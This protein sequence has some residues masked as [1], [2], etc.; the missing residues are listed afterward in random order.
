MDRSIARIGYGSVLSFYNNGNF[1]ICILDAG[2]STAR[3]R[4]DDIFQCHCTACFEKNGI[5]VRQICTEDLCG[6]ICIG[7]CGKTD[8]VFLGHS[9]DHSALCQICSVFADGEEQIDAASCSK[10]ADALVQT[11]C[12][13]TELLHITEHGNAAL[14]LFP[15]K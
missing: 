10:I 4:I 2:N 13:S 3:Q 15:G 1:R 14:S 7:I 6:G 11:R 8:N 12:L 9:A 5:A